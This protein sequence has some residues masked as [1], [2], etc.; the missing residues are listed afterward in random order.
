MKIVCTL[1]GGDFTAS[2][3]NSLALQ[4]REHAPGVEF[5]CITDLKCSHLVTRMRPTEVL[6]GWWIEMEMFRPDLTGPILYLDIDTVVVGSMSD[7]IARTELTVLRDA[8]RGARDPKAIQDSCMMLPE[9][10]RAPIWADWHARRRAITGL[11]GAMQNLFQ[12]HWADK[13]T[14]WQDVLPGQFGSYKVNGHTGPNR[15]ITFFHGR[16]R[17]WDTFHFRHLY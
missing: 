8:Y 13:A 12:Q 15:R 6:E 9:E 5:V 16:P 4:C 17:P 14:F 7:I 2:H 1:S 3:V 10:V 11:R